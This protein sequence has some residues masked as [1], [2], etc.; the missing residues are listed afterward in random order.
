MGPGECIPLVAH[1]AD[2]FHQHLRGV[3][4]YLRIYS[5]I[6]WIIAALIIGLDWWFGE[7]MGKGEQF[8]IGLAIAYAT[9]DV[10]SRSLNDLNFLLKQRL[11]ARRRSQI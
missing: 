1:P 9:F 4:A 11:R 7:P 6:C 3:M 8:M 5:A 10:A 2:G